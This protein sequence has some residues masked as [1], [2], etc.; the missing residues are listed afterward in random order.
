MNHYGVP[1]DPSSDK[2]I[3]PQQHLLYTNKDKKNYLLIDIGASI[4]IVSW[5]LT[6]KQS[7][8]INDIVISSRLPYSEFSQRFKL[9]PE[10]PSMLEKDIEILYCLI[11]RLLLASK[12]TR[13]DVYACASYIITRMDLPTNYHKDT[14]LN[15]DAL[16]VWRR[17]KWLHCHPQKT[18]ITMLRHCFMNTRTIF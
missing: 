4:S 1:V 9:N 11:A 16:F 3:I 2:G 14:H 17:H 18:K 10:S 12:I 6:K 5:K 8:I 15:L 7:H 13:P